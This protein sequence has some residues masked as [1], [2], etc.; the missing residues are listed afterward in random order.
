MNMLKDMKYQVSELRPTD[1]AGMDELA[2]R[3]LE[4]HARDCGRDGKIALKLLR[5]VRELLE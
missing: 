1:E 2:F 4:N 5:I 3:W